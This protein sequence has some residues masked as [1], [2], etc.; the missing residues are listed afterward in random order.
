MNAGLES[1]KCYILETFESPYEG[2]HKHWCVEIT[3]NGEIVVCYG[4]I[5]TQND[6]ML[7]GE[8]FIDGIK[9]VEGE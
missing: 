6:A 8:A 7:I 4:G 1:V 2:I 9:H 3:C 5:T